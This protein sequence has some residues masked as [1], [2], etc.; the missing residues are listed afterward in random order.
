MGD[1]R[2]TGQHHVVRMLQGTIDRKRIA[3]AYLLV[4]PP[5]C[6]KKA[7]ARNFAQALNCERSDPPCHECRSCTRIAS[8]QDFN[9]REIDVE[10]ERQQIQIDQ[11]REIEHRVSLKTTDSNY[12]ITIVPRAELF[13]IEAANAFLKI[14]EE[15]PPNSLLIL[16]ARARE[17]VPETLASRCIQI[18]M[19]MPTQKTIADLLSDGKPIEKSDRELILDYAEGRPNWAMEMASNPDMLANFKAR[20]IATADRLGGDTPSKLGLA[21]N[22][23]SQRRAVLEELGLLAR[24]HGVVGRA[25]AIEDAADASDPERTRAFYAT[26]GAN[27]IRIRAGIDALSAN[28]ML[29]STLD[30]LFLDLDEISGVGPI[31][32]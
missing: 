16:A 17:S 31:A 19:R 32:Q 25:Q 1:W 11:V 20:L 7:T 24:Y 21:E 30:D 18:R 5:G 8:G 15:P 2:V 10:E 27:L 28:T 12:K 26:W 6:G 14:L 3:H 13:S 22:I 9:V 29:A 23:G 4:G